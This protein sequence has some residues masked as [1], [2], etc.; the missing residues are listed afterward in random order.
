[1]E[2]QKEK[3]K[4]KISKNGIEEKIINIKNLDTK[5]K[6]RFINTYVQSK[7]ICSSGT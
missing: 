3:R 7:A 1:M 2:D 4:N 6:N 5:T